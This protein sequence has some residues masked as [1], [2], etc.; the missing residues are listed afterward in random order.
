MSSDWIFVSRGMQIGLGLKTKAKNGTL[1]ITSLREL[2]LYGDNGEVIDRAPIAQI[3][4]KFSAFSGDSVQMNGHK[5]P[6]SFVPPMKTGP[7]SGGLV[8]GMAYAAR[9]D[10]KAGNQKREEFKLLIERI[11]AESGASV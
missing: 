1:G 9:E 5:W 4:F 11:R 3:I 2:L 6:L 10:V 7:F 8:G